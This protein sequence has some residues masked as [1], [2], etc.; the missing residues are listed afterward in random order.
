QP[1]PPDAHRPTQGSVPN[2]HRRQR[3]G[4]SLLRSAGEGDRSEV[5]LR[6]AVSLL[7]ARQWREPQRADSP[8]SAQGEQH[9]FVDAAAMR[10]H[11]TETQ[12][13]PS[14]ATR[15]Q[16]SGGMLQCRLVTVALQSWTYAA[17]AFLARPYS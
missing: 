1:A 10:C 5:L 8:I 15:L 16:N 2:D 13:A 3:Y 11:R 12:H 17:P 7:G 14:Q 4:V 9:D 6:H